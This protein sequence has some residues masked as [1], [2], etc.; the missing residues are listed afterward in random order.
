MKKIFSVILLLALTAPTVFGFTNTPDSTYV[1]PEGYGGDVSNYMYQNYHRD[2]N[3]G[4]KDDFDYEDDEDY[5]MP[6]PKFLQRKK[7]ENAKKLVNYYKTLGYDVIIK[8]FEISNKNFLEL[9]VNYDEVLKNTDD[10][11]AISSVVNQVLM[12]YEEVVING[13]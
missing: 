3:R 13:G 8:K 2:N 6:L 5:A 11:A 12:K 7:E 4:F 1:P 10:T 9:L